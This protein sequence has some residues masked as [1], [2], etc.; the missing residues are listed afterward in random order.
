MMKYRGYVART[1]IDTESGLIFGEV[2]GLRDMITFQGRSVAETVAAFRESVELYLRTCAEQGL[3]PERP[4]SGSIA[5][6][7]TP[8]VHRALVALAKARGQSLNEL[9]DRVLTRVVRRVDLGAAAAPG[10]ERGRA[11]DPPPPARARPDTGL[12]A[13]AAPAAGP[14]RRGAGAGRK[15]GA[16]GRPG[17]S[18]RRERN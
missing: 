16:K 2:V 13:A 18:S 4:Y 11:A 1:E 15:A 6:R 10:P 14:P 7:T 8:R 3:E 12:G 9:V 5:V 17:S